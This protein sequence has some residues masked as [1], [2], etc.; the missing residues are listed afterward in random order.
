[1]RKAIKTMPRGDKN[2]LLAR[3]RRRQRKR[4]LAEF[5]ARKRSMLG[6]LLEFALRT[7]RELGVYTVEGRGQLA[8]INFLVR[9]VTR[10]T[11]TANLQVEGRR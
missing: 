11:P 4:S 8:T 9:N 1:M 2:A 6:I 3:W 7:A 10:L 5:K